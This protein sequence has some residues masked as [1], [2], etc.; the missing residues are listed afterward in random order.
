MV[1][2]AT[3]RSSTTIFP[4]DSGHLTRSRA[5]DQVYLRAVVN[6]VGS[7]HNRS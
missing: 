1:H 2:A 3:P 6:A 5:A 4:A 7:T